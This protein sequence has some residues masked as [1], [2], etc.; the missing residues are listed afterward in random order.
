M[1]LALTYCMRPFLKGFPTKALCL[2]ET[3]IVD[4]DRLDQAKGFLSSSSISEPSS[5]SVKGLTSLM[6]E[7]EDSACS[8]ECPPGV[9]GNR[10]I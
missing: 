7:T 9:K 8:F 6:Q 10:E 4:S 1:A 3:T 2:M 5:G